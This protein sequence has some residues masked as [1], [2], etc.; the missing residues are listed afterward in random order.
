M[1]SNDTG[2]NT[3]VSYRKLAKEVVSLADCHRNTDWLVSV[4][5][6]QYTIASNASHRPVQV[7]SLA[8]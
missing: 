1:L 4:V 2:R 5:L 8:R 3:A 6:I 7:L